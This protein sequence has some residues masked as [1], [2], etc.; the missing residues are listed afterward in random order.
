MKI[1]LL[2][3]IFNGNV[4]ISWTCKTMEQVWIHIQ[5]DTPAVAH[6]NPMEYKLYEIDLDK[7]TLEERKLPEF[8]MKEELK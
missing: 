5:Q 3:L 7:K 1:L 4:F 8:V 6:F 2:V